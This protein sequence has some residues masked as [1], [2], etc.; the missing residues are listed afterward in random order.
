[1]RI[2]KNHIEIMAA[3]DDLG[4][5]YASELER[6]TGQDNRTI[7]VR[8]NSLAVNGYIKQIDPPKDWAK[9]NPRQTGIVRFWK[10]TN[11]GIE[12]LKDAR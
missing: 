2:T 10:L 9:E 7:S 4:Q 6:K 3:L 8:L 11:K 5:S 12:V 1:M